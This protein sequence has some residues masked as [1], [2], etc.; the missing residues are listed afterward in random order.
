NERE[1]QKIPAPALTPWDTHFATFKLR[2]QLP[3]IG[4]TLLESNLREEFG[5]N[6]AIIERGD[7]YINVP[8]R[9]ERLYPNDILSVIGTDKQLQDFKN[10][11]ESGISKI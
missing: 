4:K 11:L 9:D 3:Y 10:Y 6:I 1:N 8:S 5:I 7:I 2:P